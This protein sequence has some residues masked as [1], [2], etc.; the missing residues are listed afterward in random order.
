[1]KTIKDLDDKYDDQDNCGYTW[2]IGDVYAELTKFAEEW[3]KELDEHPEKYVDIYSEW[4]EG[5]TKPDAFLVKNFI[6]HFFNLKPIGIDYAKGK[7]KTFV[8]GVEQK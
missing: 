5:Y 8:N 6:K 3:I 1:M 7:D 4:V 2:N